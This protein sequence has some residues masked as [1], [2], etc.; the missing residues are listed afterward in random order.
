MK[1]LKERDLAGLLFAG[2][3]NFVMTLIAQPADPFWM[4]LKILLLILS[5]ALVLASSAALF[6]LRKRRDRDRL[7]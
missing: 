1:R 7:Q 2:I 6:V 4:N 5:G 3:L